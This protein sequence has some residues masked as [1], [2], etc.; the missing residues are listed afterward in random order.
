MSRVTVAVQAD[1]AN[2][3]QSWEQQPFE[4]GTVVGV[5]GPQA[6]L[7][8]EQVGPL[9][10]RPAGGDVER[11]DVRHGR[12]PGPAHP[13]RSA[14][15]R[16]RP[17]RGSTPR[18][19]RRRR[20]TRRPR[21]AGSRRPTSSRRHSRRPG[22]SAPASAASCHTPTCRPVVDTTSSIRSRTMLAG[23]RPQLR[24][25]AG[26]PPRAGRQ[27]VASDVQP[28][29]REQVGERAEHGLDERPPARD[30][31]VE[32]VVDEP[33]H[34]DG[35]AR[36]VGVGELGVRR[37]GRR[38]SAPAGRPPARGRRR[39]RR[40]PRPS[41]AISSGVVGAAVRLA[42]R[43][44]Q[45]RDRQAV[46]APRADLGERRVAVDRHTPA[47]V[48]GQVQMQPVESVPRSDV[49]QPA[50]VGGREELPGEVDVQPAPLVA[51]R[52]PGRASAR[53][54]GRAR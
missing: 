12:V 43:T 52:V 5:L 16:R 4:R 33:L 30:T 53:P 39:P 32:H 9:R 51:R 26:D 36:V 23:V 22:R 46:A 6:R 34:A 44:E 11:L 49:D 20:G 1:S 40:R 19:A 24:C 2:R 3:R 17:C 25:A 37:R 54:R 21:A 50:D 47:L 28:R 35:A 29:R 14:T 7:D 38:S 27:L 8:A 31:G 48:V 10:L 42:A 18:R 13:R 41:P 15:R 45:R